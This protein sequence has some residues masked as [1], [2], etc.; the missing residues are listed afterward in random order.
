M[1]AADPRLSRFRPLKRILAH[2]QFDSGTHGWCELIGNYNGKGD[3]AT[4]DDHMRDF[5]PPQLSGCNFFDIGTHGAMS[6]TYAL[7]LATR[8][9]AGH[10]AVG[11]R[12]LT[13]SGRGLVQIEAYFTFKAEATTGDH[14]V[15]SFGGVEWD[16]NLH[17]SEAQ[18]GA[19][20]VATDICGDQGL[21]YHTVAR[22][23]NTDLDNRLSR[24]WMY[25][26]VP[27]PTPREHVQGKV[28]LEYGAD[29]TAPD[30]DDWHVFGAPQ[31]LCYNEVPTKVNWHY[32][33]WRIDTAKRRNVELQV[34][35]RVM[36]MSEVPVPP[37][38]ESYGS[39]ENLLNFYFSVRTHAPVRNFLF[40]DSVLISVDW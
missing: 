4:V 21:R 37:Y 13:M 17:P 8:P 29:F 32:L 7:K 10:T 33:R 39:L 34:N 35:D 27:E 26:A 9:I 24:R 16:G 18:F 19:F 5:R 3:L 38:A 23:Q 1:V 31:E 40:L 30:P 12:R 25:P 20:T 11:I 2:D 36:D 14:G 28:K 6:G 15:D 22:Y